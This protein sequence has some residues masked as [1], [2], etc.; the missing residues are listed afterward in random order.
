MARAATSPPRKFTPGDLQRLDASSREQLCHALLI[1]T[2]V[3]VG[4]VVPGA[5][6]FDFIVETVPLW[7]VRRSRVRLSLR[8]VDQEDIR[9]LGELATAEG[10]AEAVLI[11]AAPQT[12]SS[13]REAP[14]VSLTRASAF[15]AR[16]EASAVVQWLD[17]A[18]RVDGS[19]F[20]FLRR[21][22]TLLA[23]LDAVGIRWLPWLARN[24]VPPVLKQAGTPADALLEEAAFRTFVML[25][26]FDG[27]RLGVGTPGSVNPDALLFLP[28]GTSAALLDCKAS[29]DGY[30]MGRGDY[31][32][33]CDYVEQL[34]PEARSAGRKLEFVVI[35]SSRFKGTDDRRHPFF[36]RARDLKS[37]AKVELAYL[38][39]DDLVRLALRVEEIGALPETRVRIPWSQ[40]FKSGLITDDELLAHL[41]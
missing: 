24:K 17:G 4:E 31:R 29:R 12:T 3:R 16:L 33:I 10:H 37:K 25:F 9:V 13:L 11:E 36:R 27:K 7:G 6:F 26:G 32:A 18:P 19:I 35:L 1:E 30:Q 15:I 23:R 8:A 21:R 40:V 41:K 5:D 22:Q 14:N 34:R 2:G 28:D 39:A 20:S 38:R